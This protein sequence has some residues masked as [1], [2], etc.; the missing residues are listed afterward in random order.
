VLAARHWLEE[1]FRA[2]T[3]P[4][5]YAADW[6]ASRPSLYYYYCASVA[7]ALRPAGGQDVS[8][9]ANNQRW[10]ALLAAAL[11]KRQRQ[12]GSW[13][14]PAVDVR[15]DDPLVATSLALITLAICRD[16][17]MPNVD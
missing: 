17:A 10:A 4:G 14:N 9:G 2:D 6:E 8:A 13:A 16:S 11:L 5:Q 12:D 1:H 3:H 7:R 15:E